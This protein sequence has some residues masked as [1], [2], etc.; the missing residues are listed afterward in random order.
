MRSP[1]RSPI[2]DGAVSAASGLTVT[3]SS[4]RPLSI[5]M[6]AARAVTYGSAAFAPDAKA[7]A[8]T[9]ISTTT[10]PRIHHLQ[11]ATHRHTLILP[12]YLGKAQPSGPSS[13]PG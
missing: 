3:A 12:R 5:A 13:L 8:S 1:G 4:N 7:A 6:M 11:D 9:P 10:L 2:F